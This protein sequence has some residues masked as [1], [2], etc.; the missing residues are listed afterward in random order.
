V[1]GIYNVSNAAIT[2]TL[3]QFTSRR[4]M[5]SVFGSASAT[6]NG[7]WTVEATGRNDVSSTLPE[8]NN[9]YF[10]PSVNTSLIVTDAVGALRNDYLSFLKLRA[11]WARVGNDADPYQLNTVFQGNPNKFGGL[12]QFTLGNNQLLPTLK[13]EI[14][15]SVEGG[16]EA[17]FMDGRATIDFT[18]YRKET[19]NQ[20][21]LVPVSPTT[22]FA[23]KLIN[24]GTM[25]NN[26]FETLLTVIPLQMSNGFEWSSTFNFGKNTNKVTDLAEGVE[27]IILGN[28][29]F[30]DVRLEATK[31]QPYG[32][33]WG[34]DFRRC[35]DNAVA[36]GMCTA[37]Q[38][39]RFL[40]DGGIAVQ[41][42]TMVYLGSIQP[43]WTGGWSN[44]LSWKGWS[45]SALLDIRQGGK[46]MSYTNYV[47]MYSGVLESTL[48]GRELDWNDPGYVF[49]AI[50]IN[51]Q[52]QNTDTVTSETFFQNMFG[53]TGQTTYD[54]SYVKLRELRFGYD[55]PQAWASRLRS[56]AVSV[57][58]TGRNLALWTDVP[59]ID[60]EFAYSSGNFQGIEYAFPG[61]TRS[62][63]ISVRITP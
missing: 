8:E 38:K 34:Y 59:N 61:N 45:A 41:T 53:A 7:Y 47:G 28:G 39:G 43:D 46:L 6:V 51:T 35:D 55:L 37:A 13:P 49:D 58:L 14:T 3:G 15:E 60:P 5:N 27:R 19:R 29:L 20:I 40:S 48:K 18:V 25:Q 1:R 31:G 16:V 24:A 33:L 44:Q 50:D 26:G 21:Y 56:Q 11:S 2:P 42:D 62:W 52:A 12:P 9:S 22:G 32:A 10:Y 17:G 36:D 63:G 4:N 23:N 54:A 30:G 57:A